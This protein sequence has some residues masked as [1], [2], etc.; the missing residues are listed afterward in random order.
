MIYQSHFRSPLGSIQVLADDKRIISISFS[1]KKE[2]LQS[3]TLTFRCVVQLKEYF[4]GRRKRFDLPIFIGGTDFE[5][6]VLKN[7]LKV[8]SGA[9]I[10]YQDLAKMM[11]RPK[12]VRAVGAAL[13][14]NRIP[15][16]IPCHRVVSTTGSLGGYSGGRPR[17]KFLIEHERSFD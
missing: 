7:L 13:N 17:K 14:R 10:S 4:A 5:K 3:N 12:S 15:I 2:K 1:K 9:I 16:I 11:G 8:P 6:L